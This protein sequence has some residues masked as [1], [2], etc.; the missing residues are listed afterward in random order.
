MSCGAFEI[1]PGVM[2]M[3]CVTFAETGTKP[4]LLGHDT[5]EK[6]EKWTST[7]ETLLQQWAQQWALNMA[8]HEVAARHKRRVHVLLQTPTVLIPLLLA[9]PTGAGL[10][11]SAG[12]VTCALLVVAAACGG[13]TSMLGWQGESEKHSA[14]AYRYFDMISDLEEVLSQAPRFRPKC[15]VVIS[16]FK[17]RMDSAK[18]NSPG[19]DLF[20]PT[21]DAASETGSEL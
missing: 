3:P 9:P 10:M 21:S 6:D 19:I 8:A 18:Q 15:D 20:K 4:L 12:A 13:L 1:A 5:M 17:M 14:A 11:D 2:A 16:R 7:Q